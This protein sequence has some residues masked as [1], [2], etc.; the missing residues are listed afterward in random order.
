MSV[1]ECTREIYGGNYIRVKA[2]YK[3]STTLFIINARHVVLIEYAE[4]VITSRITTE[5]V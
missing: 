4:C 5:N 2:K 1:T 3:T